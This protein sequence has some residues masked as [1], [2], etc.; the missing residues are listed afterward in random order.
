MIQVDR[1]IFDSTLFIFKDK[2]LFSHKSYKCHS[3]FDNIK[4][5]LRSE[6]EYVKWVRRAVNG[7][8]VY[9][10]VTDTSNYRYSSD[11]FKLHQKRFYR[12]GI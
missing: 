11:S 9:N 4:A 2:V 12:N 10:R 8:H 5:I 6:Y 3:R 1:N 7:L